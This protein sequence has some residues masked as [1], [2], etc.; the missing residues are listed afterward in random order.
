MVRHGG[1][2]TDELAARAVRA[3]SRTSDRHWKNCDYNG[4]DFLAERTVRKLARM[5]R[6]LS[7]AADAED[8]I[9]LAA[10]CR[11]P[12]EL[13]RAMLDTS[14]H[15]EQLR[16]T[17]QDLTELVTE[18]KNSLQFLADAE[19]LQAFHA[20]EEAEC[21]AVGL[22]VQLLN[23]LS[24]IDPSTLQSVE[25]VVEL[26]LETGVMLSSRTACLDHFREFSGLQVLVN[27]L[28]THDH[29]LMLERGCIIVANLAESALNRYH[30][31]LEGGVSALVSLLDGHMLDGVRMASATAL[32]MMSCSD[33]PCQDALRHCDGITLLVRMANSPDTR[34]ATVAKLALDCAC[35]K[36]A[37]NSSAVMRALRKEQIASDGG[38]G[39]AA[40]LL[41]EVNAILD[42]ESYSSYS[43]SRTVSPN[44]YRTPEKRFSYGEPADAGLGRSPSPA[45]GR[46]RASGWSSPARSA[47]P[48]L[49]SYDTPR[50][51]R[52]S[53]SVNTTLS[54]RSERGSSPAR[55]TIE[56]LQSS[57]NFRLGWE[58]DDEEEPLS[59]LHGSN[60]LSSPTRPDAEARHSTSYALQHLRAC[61]PPSMLT[62]S[63]VY[64]LLLEMGCLPSEAQQVM[65][66]R[67]SGAEMLHL[68]ERDMLRK[69]HIGPI[70]TR[71]LVMIQRAGEMFDRMTRT[72]MQGKISEL[73]FRVFLA[74][75]GL[76][77]SDISSLADKFRSLRAGG[78]GCVSFLEWAKSYHYFS[79]LLCTFGLRD[80]P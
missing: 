33:G 17:L 45:R 67:L 30:L 34:V 46:P 16:P 13:L 49:G 41:A 60:F 68:S 52:Y 2:A 5:Q 79:N 47:S 10:L 50:T 1:M 53:A 15:L 35:E 38:F 18:L 7:V 43:P 28:D 74:T 11:E 72:A 27:I 63:E 8:R 9:E 56:I 29:S 70:V 64:S 25:G 42:R 55:R 58:S 51:T 69:L 3:L 77:G 19:E 71:K 80:V 21:R 14:T 22:V 76:R 75:Q 59:R 73:E 26:I 39:R 44:Q 65:D 12:V 62:P 32:A 54:P 31:R 24:E 66:L 57:F 61:K 40:A 6:S 36:N 23:R 20:L 78:D 48:A 37:Q 4:I